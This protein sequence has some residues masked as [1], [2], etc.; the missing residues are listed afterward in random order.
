MNL[1]RQYNFFLVFLGLLLQTYANAQLFVGTGTSIYVKNQVV[2]VSQDLELKDA[3]SNFYLRNGSQLLQGTT[4]QGANK[5]LGNLSVFQEGSVN[6][7]QYNY[8]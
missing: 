5:G 6:N 1:K 7:Y 4:V 3:S 2:Y 8:L